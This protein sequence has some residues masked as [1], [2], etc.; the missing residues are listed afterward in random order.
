MAI[1]N[2]KARTLLQK[3]PLLLKDLLHNLVARQQIQLKIAIL[4]YD[5]MLKIILGKEN[6]ISQ[7][8]IKINLK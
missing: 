2:H 7:C 4:H 1:N 8:Q 5:F 3:D 6:D